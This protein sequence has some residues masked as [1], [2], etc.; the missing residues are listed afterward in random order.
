MCGHATIAVGRYAV[1]HRLVN[2]V[3]PETVVKM[4]CPCGLIKMIVEYDVDTGQT[5]LTRFHSVPSFAFAV[6][7]QIDIGKIL[8]YLY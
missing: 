3:S 4:Q 1:D 6:N 8:K 2:P 7:Q 5:G